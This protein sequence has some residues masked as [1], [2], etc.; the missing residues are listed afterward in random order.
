MLGQ[1][2]RRD[3]H[4]GA[5][6][7]GV[8]AK[9]EENP[10][11]HKPVKSSEVGEC[12]SKPN[13]P[14][15]EDRGRGHQTAGADCLRGERQ[16]K[17]GEDMSR[18]GRRE[19]GARIEWRRTHTHR[20]QQTCEARVRA[21][22][23]PIHHQPHSRGRPNMGNQTVERCVSLTECLYSTGC[24]Y[25]LP[26]DVYYRHPCIQEHSRTDEEACITERAYSNLSME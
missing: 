13:S 23:V 9:I 17:C 6:A 18:S 25:C 2:E 7:P 24:I 22:G 10:R 26:T 8:R 4:G 3:D 1:Y 19:K 14:T 5:P 16:E 12:P 21:D 11:C 20:Y 15:H